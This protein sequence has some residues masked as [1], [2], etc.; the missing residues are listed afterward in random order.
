ME[1]DIRQNLTKHQRAA[2]YAA[3]LTPFVG[4]AVALLIE[5]S[6][7]SLYADMLSSG[8][9]R[10]VEAVD[11]YIKVLASYTPQPEHSLAL[12]AVMW[13]FGI[14]YAT[15]LF[16]FNWPGYKRQRELWERAI[17]DPRWSLGRF[18]IVAI[19]VISAIFLIYDLHFEPRMFSLQSSESYTLSH[20]IFV[21]SFIM[22][23]RLGLAIFVSS[24]SLG[25][26]ILYWLALTILMNFRLFWSRPTSP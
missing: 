3:I 1:F 13:I 12:M 19:L 10:L 18:H 15:V 14:Y 26:P 20:P 25:K 2:I 17:N 16:V 5:F 4:F 8:F 23:T 21:D 9:A 7:Q 22:R 24:R 6:P 11:P